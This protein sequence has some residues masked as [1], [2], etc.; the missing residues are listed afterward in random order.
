MPVK[1][2]GGDVPQQKRTPFENLPEKAA[3]RQL[4][5]DL[6]MCPP[7]PGRE[8]VSLQGDPPAPAATG[9]GSKD[10][11]LNL[12]ASSPSSQLL[13]QPTTCTTA[14]Q[15]PPEP[16]P[17]IVHLTQDSVHYEEDQPISRAAGRTVCHPGITSVSAV[18][19]PNGVISTGMPCPVVHIIQAINIGAACDVSN[20][21]HARI[22]VFH[23]VPEP[24]HG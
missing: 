7:S 6:A 1:A 22:C 10:Q 3:A 13:N 24:C 2:E 4:S 15:G 8:L 23:G 11:T 12:V 20:L 16:W 17:I 5:G 14:V 18:I 19:E 9:Q 21:V